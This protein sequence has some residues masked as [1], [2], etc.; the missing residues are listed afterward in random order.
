MSRDGREPARPARP[1]PPVAHR[2]PGA[3]HGRRA[4]APDRRD[5]QPRPPHRDPRGGGGGRPRRA[6]VPRPGGAHRPDRPGDGPPRLLPG[7]ST[8][9]PGVHRHPLRPRQLARGAAGDRRVAGLHGLHVL[10]AV[11]LPAPG[12][13]LRRHAGRDRPRGRPARPGGRSGLRP[14]D[15]G[16]EPGRQGPGGG[17]GVRL[18]PGGRH[19]H[20]LRPPPGQPGPGHGGD[21][22][23][24]H[25]GRRQR[26]HRPPQ[27][28]RRGRAAPPGRPRPA[29]LRPRQRGARDARIAGPRVPHPGRRGAGPAA[30][31]GGHRAGPGA[32]RRRRGAVQD[33]GWE[34]VLPRGAR[35][36][37]RAGGRG[38]GRRRG[39]AEPPGRPPGPGGGARGRG[40]RRRRGRAGR[41]RRARSLRA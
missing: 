22:P 14:R 41:P 1:A 21:P 20:P 2:R 28:Q 36:H 10:R 31:Q 23:G 7:R 25:R 15:T 12:P 40:R 35:R 33:A 6:R 3:R 9:L 39:G 8:E 4:G 32:P 38:G 26:G 34:A 16:G 13:A 18:R 19:H 30:G 5:H 17:G 29:P 11:R 37:G 24:L 27:A